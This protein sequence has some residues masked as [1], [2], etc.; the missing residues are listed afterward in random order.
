MTSLDHDL[1]ALRERL[2]AAA[3]DDLRRR[4]RRRRIAHLAPVLAL[5]ARPPRWRSR[6]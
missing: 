5:T 1:D 4:A 3:A 2:R 6:R